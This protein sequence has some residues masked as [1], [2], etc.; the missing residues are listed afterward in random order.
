MTNLIFLSVALLSSFQVGT[1]ALTLHTKME[2]RRHQ[3]LYTNE[4]SSKSLNLKLEGMNVNLFSRVKR[5]ISTCRISSISFQVQDDKSFCL[6][7]M[8][9]ILRVCSKTK[10]DYL[11]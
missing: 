5:L 11:L 1:V 2:A 7:K 6:L 8:Y 3:R 9:I 4:F 10:H